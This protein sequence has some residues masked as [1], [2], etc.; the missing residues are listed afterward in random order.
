MSIV[1]FEKNPFISRT[2]FAGSSNKSLDAATAELVVV[3]TKF[4]ICRIL[5]PVKAGLNVARISRHFF[6][7]S[8]IKAFP[9]SGSIFSLIV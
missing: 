5:L 8:E 4:T 2:P 6:P 7:D 3:S 9:K 1:N